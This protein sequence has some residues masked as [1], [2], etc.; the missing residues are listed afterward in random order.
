MAPQVPQVASFVPAPAYAAPAPAYAA[1]APA[2][3]AP[4]PA[5]IPDPETVEKQKAGYAKALEKQF[6]DGVG[7]IASEVQVKKQQ[8]AA[9][10][11]KKKTQYRLQKEAELQGQNLLL[12]QQMH[13]Q[14][15]MLQ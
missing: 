8:L 10:A 3:A 15:M 2:Y 13:S 9:A 14:L 5:T 7:Q 1:P 4:A 6:T 12:D 11:A